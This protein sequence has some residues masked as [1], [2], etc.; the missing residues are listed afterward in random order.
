MGKKN[1]SILLKNNTKNKK[2][3]SADTTKNNSIHE[4]LALGSTVS[5]LDRLEGADSLDRVQEIVI[6]M[7]A[8]KTKEK[9]IDSEKKASFG[10]GGGGV[11]SLH[12]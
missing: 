9:F 2:S 11:Y 12:C 7:R 3:G 10:G 4:S 1:K 8:A 6:E 5:F